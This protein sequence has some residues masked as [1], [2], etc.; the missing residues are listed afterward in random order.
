M[1]L[2]KDA[3]DFLDLLQKLGR[4]R[5]ETLP[6][7]EAKEMFRRGRLVTQ[8]DLPQVDRVKEY[9]ASGSPHGPVPVRF[10]RGAGTADS[11]PLPVHVYYHGGGWVLGDLDSHDWVCRRIA[12]EVQCAV[13]SV[14]YRMAP[15][16]IF[17]AA[18]DD[19]SQP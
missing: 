4:P 14:D 9:E 7:A 2:D 16:H 12:N 3:Q 19:S 18:Y 17:P 1:A 15:E 6:P 8:P 10:Y 13:V 11:G 5:I